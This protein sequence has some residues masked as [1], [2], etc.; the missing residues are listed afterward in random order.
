MW[1]SPFQGSVRVT[2]AKQGLTPLPVVYRP[3]GTLG[4][5]YITVMLRHKSLE[6]DI[7]L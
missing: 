1:V 3:F 6:C 7:V 2:L 5:S 4:I